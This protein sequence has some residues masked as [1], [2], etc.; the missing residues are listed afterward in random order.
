MLAV[1]NKA[2]TVWSLGLY[3]DDDFQTSTFFLDDEQRPYA[4]GYPRTVSQDVL[5]F[6]CHP[7]TSLYM[8]W[9]LSIGAV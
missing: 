6:A 7:G 2:S 4:N 9:P 3:M 5:L 1:D 8:W